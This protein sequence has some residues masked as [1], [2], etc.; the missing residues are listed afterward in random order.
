MH[1]GGGFGYVVFRVEVGGAGGFGFGTPLALVPPRLLMFGGGRVPG[2]AVGGRGL[3]G[4]WVSVCLAAASLVLAGAPAAGAAPGAPAEPPPPQENQRPADLAPAD[5]QAGQRPLEGTLEPEGGGG[6]PSG[7]GVGG[8]GSLDG[9]GG[10]EGGGGGLGPVAGDGVGVADVLGAD[11]VYSWSDGGRVVAVRRLDGAPAGAA[12]GASEFAGGSGVS[13]NSTLGEWFV[14]DTGQELQLFGGVVVIFRS[15]T[16]SAEMGEVLAR[17]GASLGD[18]VPIEGLAG[19]FLVEASPEESLALAAGLAGEPSVAAASPNWHSPDATDQSGAGSLSGSEAAGGGDAAEAISAAQRQYCTG[20]VPREDW[21]WSDELHHCAWHLDASTAFRGGRGS[22]VDPVVDINIGDVWDQTMGQ[23]VTV[24][25]VDSHWNGGHEDLRD[26]A[27]SGLD[28]HWGG[29]YR[30]PRRLGSVPVPGGIAIGWVANPHGTAVAGV[31]GAR[32]NGVG[33]RGVAPRAT[34]ANFNYLDHQRQ[35]TLLEGWTR[36]SDV[37]GVSNHSYGPGFPGLSRVSG[38]WWA[39][40]D[41]VLASGLGGLGTV[42]TKSAGNYGGGRPY[43]GFSVYRER[44]NHRGVVTVCAV[45][46]DGRQSAY[47]NEGPNLWLCAPSKGGSGGIGIVTTVGNNQYSDTFGGTSAA[48]PQVAGVA[49]L[50]RSANSN[51]TWRDVKVLLADTAQKND[52]GDSSWV[53]GAAKYSDS[54]ATYSYSRKYGFG[55]V[56]AEAAVAA[57]LSWT[58]L[59]AEKV[60]TTTSPGPDVVLEDDTRTT[61]LSLS[62]ATGIDFVEHVNLELD[63]ETDNFRDFDI[64]LVSPTGRESAISTYASRCQRNCSLNGMFRFATTRHLG[65]DPNGTW[66]LRFDYR[67]SLENTPADV[68]DIATV[69]SWALKIYGHT[70]SATSTVAWLSLTVGGNGGT[71]ATLLEGED[72]QVSVHLHNG[73]LTEDLAVSVEFAKQTPSNDSDTA[74]DFSAPASVTISAGST[75]ASVTV[76]VADDRIAEGTEKFAVRL[77]AVPPG[78]DTVGITPT[79]I[80]EDLPIVS[81][82]GGAEVFEGGDAEFTVSAV[83]A[84]SSPTAVSVSVAQD[85]DFGV[86]A[87]TRTVTVPVSGSVSFT[88]ATVDDAVWEA[89]GS[90]T[91]TVAPGSG[92]GVGSP[93]SA[94]VVVAEYR[95]LVAV[96]GGPKVFEGGDAVFTLLALPAPSSP[97]SLEVTVSVGGAGD[98]GVVTGSRTVTVPSS[99]LVS[100]SVATVDDDVAESD[101]STNVVVGQAAHYRGLSDW[102]PSVGR[103]SLRFSRSAV[104][105]VED[106]EPV[107]SVSGG[108][109]VNEG[110]D[111]VFTV[112]VSPAPS[113]PS[114][115]SVSVSVSQTGDFGVVTGTRTVSVPASGSAS[116]TVGTADDDVAEA[117]GSVTATVEP[118]TRY[119]VGSASSASVVV[120]DYE[121]VVS[122]SGGD[123]VFEGGDAVFTVSVSPAPS[124]PSSVSVSV[125]VSQTGDFGVVTG[126]RTVSVPASGSA[127]FTVGTADDGVAEADGS[128]TATVE[129]GTR[130][131]VGSASS[132][133]VVV[134]D[135]E[136]VVSISGGDRVFEGGDAVFTVSAVPAPSSPMA[137]SVSVS[138]TGDFGVVTGARSVSVPVSGSASFTV[139]T[140]DDSVAEA[141]G[142]VTATVESGTRYT[143]GSASSASVVV[144]DYEPVV[145]ISGG[146]RVFEGGDAVF[147]VSAVPAP[148]SPMAVSVSVSQTGD[149]GVVTGARSVSVPVSGS[150]SFSVATVDDEAV[151]VDGS[152]TATVESGTR[153]R[154]G[155]ASSASVVVADYEP[156]VSISGG[157]RVFEGG[158]AVFMVSAVPVPSSPMAVSVSVSQTGDFGVVTGARSVSVPVSGSA[159]FT[160]ATADDSVAEADGSVTAT[161]ESGTRYKVGSASSASVVVADYEPVVSISGGGRVFE[162][163]DAVFMVSAVPAPSSP[164]AVSVSITQDGDFGVVT[165][166]RSVSVPV[167]GSASFTVATAADGVAEADGSVTATVVPETHYAVGSASSVSVTVADDDGIVV[168]LSSSVSAVAEA[169]GEAVV[170]VSLSRPLVSNDQVAEWVRVPLSVSGGTEGVHWKLGLRRGNTVGGVVLQRDS[171]GP[172][173]LLYNRGQAAELVLTALPNTDAVERTITMA[174][175]TGPRAP[176]GGGID[177]VFVRAGSVSVDIVNDDTGLPLV[178]VSAGGDVTEGGDAQFT[179][180]AV[181]APSA[182]LDVDVTVAATGD[183]GAATGKRTVTVPPSGSAT[184]SVGTA[185][186]GDDEPDG[187]ITATVEPGSGYTRGSPF[188]ASVAIADDDHAPKT[189]PTLSISGGAAITEG[190]TA[191]FTVTAVP[192]PSKPMQVNLLL[193]GHGNFRAVQKASTVVTMPIGGSLSYSVLTVDDGV[194]EPDGSVTVEVRPSRGFAL[195]SPTA[196]SV[197]VADND[198]TPGADPV[199]SITAIG[200]VTEGSAAQFTVTAVPAPTADLDVS[201]TVAQSGDYGVAGGT[202]TVTVPT[203]GSTTLSVSTAGDDIDEPDGS[204]TAT[205]NSG[206]GYTVS[207]TAAAATAAIADDDDPPPPVVSISSVGDVTEG[208]AAQFT[209]TA[210]PAPAAN[211]AVSVTVTASGDY[212]AATGTRTVTVPAS[213][214][215]TLSVSTTGDQTDEPDG[216]VTATVNTSAAYTVSATAGAATVSVADDDDPP[217]VVPEVSIAAVGDVTEG[218]AAQFTVTASPA[219]AADLAVSVTVTAAGDFGAATGARTVTVPASGSATLSVSTTGDQTDEPDGSVTATV[220]TSADYTVSATAGAA[221]VSVADDDDPPPVVVP[222]VSISSVGDVT[223]G[224][225]A[226][227]T[228]TASPAPAAD[229]AVSVTV[230]ATGEFG[231]PVGARTVT[232]A[233]GANS[234]TLTVATTG[235]QTDEPDGSVTA[236]VNTSA[237]YTVSATAGVATA[238][239]ADDDDP[240][241]P[242]VP[243]ITVEEASATEGGLLEFRILLSRASTQKITINWYATTAWHLI[244]NRAHRSDYQP[245]GGTMEFEPGTTAL[246]ATVW[247][248]HDSQDEPDEHFA[249]EAFL[250]GKWFTPADVGT[251]TIIDDD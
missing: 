39:A 189:L 31:V 159:S 143:V 156:V 174:V 68:S 54:Q 112:S 79:V 235:D 55:V 14:T 145:S 34:L 83:P 173:V 64:T 149:F 183:F 228:V 120:A 141:D 3:L 198:P 93:S 216:S 119:T 128:V 47:S 91:A 113:S 76:T 95:P 110:G 99:G 203:S 185:D 199:V 40:I 30:E 118:G 142:S 121:P 45:G 193:G 77:V 63:M 200:D 205:V 94:S 84:P 101:G 160:V 78:Y 214:S 81:I 82:S 250:P 218:S 179:V 7:F 215:A 191:V 1:R 37:V 180:T 21:K 5:P 48:A 56:D 87:G 219:P 122:I 8:D 147:T 164:M 115:V 100:F 32:D 238:A 75:T 61:E 181:P 241:G 233:S 227:F 240:P 247:L 12:Q 43:Q 230:A 65:E 187:S 73:P 243:G 24:A 196:A 57:A 148:S 231:A 144:A 90:V 168:S 136:P 70:A 239:V 92:Y 71:E 124:S 222:V 107:V 212:G 109:D 192:P 245:T 186:D 42:F 33:S 134:A 220:N 36:G 86:V 129:S 58:L 139:A 18:A 130:Y 44:N 80:I 6:Q 74:T 105:E 197:A 177:E 15:G 236:T 19:A 103:N 126:T 242:D 104:V 234:A 69:K 170:T 17:H 201:V 66:K 166:A 150:A 117:D 190:G 204:V 2:S 116:F 23:G 194:D 138:Q 217:P 248:E 88:V 140:A 154:V 9:G 72:L 188:S 151:E 20:L 38:V 207:A 62:V 167:S 10:L 246:T 251:M 98:F 178:S 158:D 22:G 35:W 221:T 4:V 161:V 175:G 102:E 184:F 16:S 172:S 169:S 182:D 27:G 51:L 29:Q 89:D 137:V 152:V 209:V 232:I 41:A 46:P 132:A 163:G 206:S 52:P 244:D 53:A 224:S 97:S 108:G 226:Q 225:A 96:A 171:V 213:G 125:S 155:S 210:S 157:G 127:S 237:D 211:L 229:L 123:R 26:N 111:A 85:G 146:G 133:S 106:Y 67:G 28:T 50:V 249:V 223:E 153:Y 131:T 49:A 11:G 165:G 25:I 114:S 202:R 162:G 59:P 13:D 195:G 135:Y 176:A 60:S 208:S